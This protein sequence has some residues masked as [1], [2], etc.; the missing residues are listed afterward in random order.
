MGKLYCVGFGPG[1]SKHRTLKAVEAI[2]SS[3]V[4]VGYKVYIDEVKD[5]IQNQIIFQSGMGQEKERCQEAIRYALE[6]Y[7]VSLVCSG[8]SGLYGMAGLTYQLLEQEKEKEKVQIEVVPGVT[9]A[10]SVASLLGAPIVE[11]FCTISLSDYMVSFDKIL[12]RLEMAALGDF[13]IALY[14]AKSKKR[15]EHLEKAV[16]VL[17]QHMPS[18]RPVGIVKHAYRENQ[19]IIKTTLGAIPYEKVDMF[20]TL[21][22]GNSN[23]FFQ[24]EVFITARGYSL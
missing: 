7:N 21:I 4:I 17:L 3:Q 20:S 2:E 13:T 10:L 1:G 11:D 14:N 23:S 12:K 19:E 22:I 8:D 9:A 15:P 5:L 16:Q 6:G 24:G 18:H